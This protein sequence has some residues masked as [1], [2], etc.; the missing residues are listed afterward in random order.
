MVSGSLV[1]FATAYHTKV[2]KI[3]L[4]VLVL[5]HVS[6]IVF[7]RV[8]RGENLVRPML[9]GDKELPEA[10]ES[11]RDDA[12]SRIKA[13]LLFGICAGCVTTLVQWAA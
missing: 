1:S 13:L 12:G 11:S 9:N 7:Y 2:G 10:F 3:I 8:K 6:A 4:I 5:L